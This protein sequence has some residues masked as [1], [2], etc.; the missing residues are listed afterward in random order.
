MEELELILEMVFEKSNSTSTKKLVLPAY[1][2]NFQAV[3]TRIEECFSIPVCVQKVTYQNNEV[4]DC[5]NPRSFYLQS[6]DMLRVLCP[7]TGEVAE[8]QRAVEWLKQCLE[9]L[10]D[11]WQ[12]RAPGNIKP[13]KLPKESSEILW[14]TRNS[15]LIKSGLFG[16]WSRPCTEVNCHHFCALGGVKLLVRFH[17]LLVQLRQENPQFAY[18]KYYF[19]L[20]MICC[21]GISLFCLNNELSKLMAGSGGLESCIGSLLVKPLPGKTTVAFQTVLMALRAI[22]K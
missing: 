10:D 4:L 3:K 21:Q 22:Y 1:P 12:K 6:G 7:H 5:W 15:N 19:Y 9:I 17:K 8:V 20:E 11:V 16:S 14:S 2:A 18:T 13:G